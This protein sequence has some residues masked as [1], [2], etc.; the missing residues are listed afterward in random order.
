LRDGRVVSYALGVS[1]CGVAVTAHHATAIFLLPPLLGTVALH[2]SLGSADPVRIGRRAAA[3]A[4]G[5]GL[6]VVL[7]ILPFWVWHATEYVAQVPIDHQSRH[8]FLQERFAQLLFFWSEHG[9]LF[10]ALAL[11]LP[12][13][14]RRFRQIFP[15]YALAGL[16]FVIGLGGTTPV[17]RILFGS[18]WDWLTYDRFSLWAHV[19][20]VMLLG[21]V[22]TRH[23]DARPGPSRPARLA[24][25]LT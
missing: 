6:V 15:W 5:V 11:A 19:P 3:A 9:V 16:L 24:W 14:R 8:D 4:I 17:P 7:A 23:L 18:Q 10:V 25:L 1:L 20:L 21:A 2:E 22:A 13:L 12:L